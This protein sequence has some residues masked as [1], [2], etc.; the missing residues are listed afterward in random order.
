MRIIPLILLILFTGIGLGINL[1]MHGKEKTGKH[2]FWFSLIS[3]I[4]E[5]GLIIW[6]IW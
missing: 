2:S 5:W 1:A 3:A 4:I 6:L